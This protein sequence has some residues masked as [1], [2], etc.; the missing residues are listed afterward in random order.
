MRNL[1]KDEVIDFL[2]QAR[3]DLTEEDWKEADL[4]TVL[5]WALPTYYSWL[6]NGHISRKFTFDK[7]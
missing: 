4:I 6:N 3:P 2:K 1:S 5:S 7:D